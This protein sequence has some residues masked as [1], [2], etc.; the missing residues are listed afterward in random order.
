MIYVIIIKMMFIAEIEIVENLIEI[1]IGGIMMIVEE[2]VV[3][4]VIMIEEIEEIEG[5]SLS[6]NRR[7]GR[8]EG[9]EESRRSRSR[10]P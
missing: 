8:V 9:V 6:T 1:E 2:G 7:R 3:V 10:A 5:S 4:I